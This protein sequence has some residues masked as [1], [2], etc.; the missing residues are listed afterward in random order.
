VESV[1]EQIMQALVAAF[2]AVQVGEPPEDPFDQQFERVTRA[3]LGNTNPRQ[4]LVIG[5][6]AGPESKDRNVSQQRLAVMRVTLQVRARV[7]NDVEPETAAHRAM[8]T[9]QRVLYR[10]NQL[11]GLAVK[12]DDVESDIDVDSA[13]DK[14]VDAVIS[15]EVTY[16]HATRDPRK[17]V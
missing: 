15:V 9:A 14:V 5:I 6:Y 17:V 13:G 11:G 1:R 12:M 10:N 2:T 3:D 8:A 7:P 16:R 4:D